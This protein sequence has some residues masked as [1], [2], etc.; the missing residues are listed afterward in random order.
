MNRTHSNSAELSEEVR[1]V[2]D[3]GKR[4]DASV[5][6]EGG[7][8]AAVMRCAVCRGRGLTTVWLQKPRL[9][10]VAVHLFSTHC[11]IPSPASLARRTCIFIHHI[12]V[13]IY[14]FRVV[15]YKGISVIFITYAYI[16]LCLTHWA[17]NISLKVVAFRSYK[18]CRRIFDLCH[19]FYTN[20]AFLTFI[21]RACDFCSLSVNKGACIPVSPKC[22]AWRYLCLACCL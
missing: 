5:V 16:L 6:V 10:L 12:G 19:N 2:F 17:C 1:V 18:L 3:V 7:A 9:G 15:V 20:T 11:Y 14:S 4:L 21:H 22:F 13:P 8:L